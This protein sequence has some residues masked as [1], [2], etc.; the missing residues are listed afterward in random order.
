MTKHK[1]L[2]ETLAE[3]QMV[4]T[5]SRI[6]E[7]GLIDFSASL[8]DLG[9]MVAKLII[10]GTVKDPQVIESVHKTA[11]TLRACQHQIDEAIRSTDRIQNIIEEFME[12]DFPE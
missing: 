2:K 4:H 5:A 8:S 11:S 10:T 3:A 9:N 7:N 6:A 12:I 1:D